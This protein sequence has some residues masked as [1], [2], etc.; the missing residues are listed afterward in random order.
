MLCDLVLYLTQLCLFI[1]IKLNL[2]VSIVTGI[3]V[4][5]GSGDPAMPPSDFDM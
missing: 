5:S 3:R 2:T 1:G 4:E